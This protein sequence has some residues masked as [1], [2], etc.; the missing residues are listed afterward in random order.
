MVLVAE[1]ALSDDTNTA[2]PAV[3]AALA[4]IAG[5][6]AGDAACCAKL[7]KRPRGQ[8]HTEATTMLSTVSPH[9]AEMAKDLAVLLAA[10][11]ESHYGLSLV[12]RTK[13]KQMVSRA[14]R[15]VDR[16]RLV[17]NS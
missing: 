7:R 3:A 8:S 6:A 17:V 15:L 12:G 2:T 5:V 11:D 16:A 4:V 14:Q 9:G 10:K 13:A 1:L